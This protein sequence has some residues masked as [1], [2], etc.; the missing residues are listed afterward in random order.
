MGSLHRLFNISLGL[1]LMWATAAHAT[2]QAMTPLTPFTFKAIYTFQY[3]GIYFGKIGVESEQSDDHYSITADVASGGILKI[4]T[5]HSSHTTVDGTGA[6]FRYDHIIYDTH[7]KTKN[8]R[9]AVY[10]EYQN[11][12]VIKE[13]LVPPDDRNK[14][15]A[16]PDVLKNASFD[17]LTFNMELRRQFWKALRKKQTGFSLTAY[18]GRRLHKID[19]T[20]IGK[21]TTLFAD[22]QKFPVYSMTLR[23][24][25]I[26]GFTTSELAKLGKKEPAVTID[27]S[28]DNRF[29][30]IKVEVPFLFGSLSA[31]LA[32]ECRTGESCLL[33]IKE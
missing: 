11:K 30:P 17:L 4:I 8:K 9:K 33:G 2:E 23:R 10:L 32:K 22:D 31:T 18:D 3:G 15:P 12:K 5:Q 14:R 13:T 7:Y 1:M 28:A 16:V 24:T 26:A 19:V 20:I 25:P 21:R 29:I 27:Y 6:H